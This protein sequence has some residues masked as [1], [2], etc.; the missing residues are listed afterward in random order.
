MDLKRNLK[1]QALILEKEYINSLSIDCVIFGFHK[2]SLK[3]LLVQ[4]KDSASWML[5]G[6][7]IKTD[8]DIDKAANRILFESTGAENIYLNQFKTFGDIIRTKG[9]LHDIDES[10][11]QAGR[12]ISIGY[13]ALVDYY[14]VTPVVDSLSEDSKW[15]DIDK[16]PPLLI[17][18]MD[19]INT[20]L[21][22]LRQQLNFKPIGLNLLPDTFTMPELQCLYEIILNK[23]LNRG[24]FY[25]K[26]MKYNI[27]DKQPETRKG[28]AH[29]APNLY[30][31][32]AERYSEA[33]ENGFKEIW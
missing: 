23:K 20:A 3:I 25:R 18:H 6:G 2:N 8:E 16:I 30:K 19:I 7:Y 28:G 29:K 27:L 14:S 33:L 15:L 4:L 13:Y 1:K 10:L 21:A 22:T 9:F 17:D 24:S 5:P 31:F 11:W 12:F 26:M 32:N